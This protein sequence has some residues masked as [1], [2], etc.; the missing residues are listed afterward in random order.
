MK[1]SLEAFATND[2]DNS[3]MQTKELNP[4]DL[5]GWELGVWKCI[6]ILFAIGMFYR[7]TALLTLK[8]LVTKLQ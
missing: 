2:L 7:F 4:I 6:I 3:P 5:L 8:L 1:Y